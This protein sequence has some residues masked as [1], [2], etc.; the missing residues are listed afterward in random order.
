[1]LLRVAEFRSSQ[2]KVVETYSDFRWIVGLRPK[3]HLEPNKHPTKFNT[4]QRQST[5]FNSIQLPPTSNS[6]KLH[7]GAAEL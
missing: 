6:A 2:L 1:M 5:P 4:T 7:L 3:I